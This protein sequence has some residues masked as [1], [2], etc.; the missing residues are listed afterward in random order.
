MP[1]TSA[2]QG[3]SV[4]HLTFHAD[5]RGWLMELFRL[6][7]IAPEKIPA[8]GYISLTNAG[9]TRGPHE[10]RTQTDRF[11]FVGPSTFRIYLWDNRT[12]S[13]SYGAKQ[14][15]E[16][17]EHEPLVLEV[18]PGVVHAYK[19]VG[20]VGGLVY[21]FPDRLYAGIDKKEP[22]DEIRH[23]DDLASPFKIE[24]S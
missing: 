11:A 14:V 10:H 24:E 4:K 12:G 7:E 8:M 2:I 16:A 5:K 1:V 19:N 23:E 22:V 17:G 9:M 6:D 21:N 20:S 18:P 15:I 3:V 13:A